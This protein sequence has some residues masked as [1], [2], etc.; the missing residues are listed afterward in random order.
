MTF[1]TVYLAADDSVVVNGTAKECADKLHKSI[2][3]FYSLVSKNTLGHQKKYII[4]KDLTN[5]NDDDEDSAFA[6]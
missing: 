2:N 3:C 5:D 1:Y 4:V 6:I